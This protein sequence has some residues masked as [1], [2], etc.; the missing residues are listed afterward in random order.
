MGKGRNKKK[1][2]QNTVSKPLQSV[3]MNLP[4]NM[5]TEEMQHIIACAIVEAEEIKA[6]KEEEQRKA[7]LLEWH[8]IIGYKENENKLKNF[9]NKIKVFL[10]ILFLPKK[11]IEG[12][13]ASIILLKSFIAL[14][15][16]IMKWC[17]LLFVIFLIGCF[18]IQ[19]IRG[20]ISE[21][22]WQLYSYCIPFAFL[23]FIFSRLFRM[24]GIEIDNLDDR[25]YLFGLFASITSLVSIIIA[26]IAIV[27][28]A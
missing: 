10:K 26:V 6:Q 23:A 19:Y 4:E 18:P 24:A 7:A 21:F 11:H 15:F 22:P 2:K 9:L 16:W 3:N 14:F 5:S 13:R 12:D 20:S 8:K 25:N 27:K 1:A 28:E 17:S